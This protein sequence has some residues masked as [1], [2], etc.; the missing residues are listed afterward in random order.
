MV[1]SH[2]TVSAC[3]A[4]LSAPNQFPQ[5][6]HAEFL[7]Q[8]FRLRAGSIVPALCREGACSCYT[9]MLTH[10]L[11]SRSARPSVPAVIQPATL[12]QRW[13]DV[14][15][16]LKV[17]TRTTFVCDAWSQFPLRQ[18]KERKNSNSL[19]IFCF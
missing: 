8:S 6:E 4:H 13:A 9:R 3:Q 1:F 17:P 19:G 12:A 16:T 10:Y 5:M 18:W 11:D 2:A 7:G 15:A 14:K